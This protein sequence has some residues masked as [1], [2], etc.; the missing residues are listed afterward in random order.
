M[1][2][3]PLVEIRV[4][5][6]VNG[7]AEEDVDAVL[8]VLVV[9]ALRDLTIGVRLATAVVAHENDVLESR[10]DR[11]FSDTLEDGDQQRVGEP[12]GARQGGRGAIGV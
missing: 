7:V 4:C 5:L 6:R 3:E 12:D 1:V 11:L 9:Q 8:G 2:G 10:G